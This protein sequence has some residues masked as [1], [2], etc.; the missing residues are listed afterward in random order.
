LVAPDLDRVFGYRHKI[1]KQLFN[2]RQEKPVR[3]SLVPPI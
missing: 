1:L 2:P 3:S